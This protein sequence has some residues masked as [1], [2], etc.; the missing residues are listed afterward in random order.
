M[1]TISENL[2][3]SIKA[4][5]IH[6][7]DAAAKYPYRKALAEAQWKSL[8][9]RRTG[10]ELLRAFR[11]SLTEKS[12]IKPQEWQG[13]GAVQLISRNG[14]SAV[15]QAE[16]ATLEITFLAS[17]LVRVR[18]YQPGKEHPPVPYAIAKPEEDWT[19]L[20]PLKFTQTES[21]LLMTTDKLSLG[22]SLDDATIFFANANGDLMR[23]DVDMAWGTDGVVRHRT[24]MVAEEHI[25]GLGERATPWN[26][27]RRTHILWNTDPAGYTDND[28][29]INMNIPTYV[30]V[31]NAGSYLVFYENTYYAEFDMGE[32]LPNIAEHRFAG[33]ELRYYIA[34][35]STKT[36]IERYTELT[37][38][39][40]LQPLWMLG[41]QQSRWS[42]YPEE[43]V[44]KLAQD[45]R[46]HDVP[47]D[48]IHLDI[49]YME[50]FRNFTWD[51]ERFPDLARLAADLRE[52]GIK[53]I[54]IID[55]GVKKDPDYDTYRT[56]M[57]GDLFCKLPD[58]KTFHAP[59]WPGMCAFPDFTDSRTRRWWGANYRSLLEAGIAGFW[60]DMNEP[61][62][63][64]SQT[65]QTL[66][67]TIYHDME[68]QGGDHRE[69]HNIYGMQMVRA[70]REGL[71]KL[72]PDQRPVVM[73]RAGWAG[74][75]R[76][77]TS[78][79]A[80]N[81]STWNSLRLTIPLVTALGLSGVSFTG[82]D[83]GGFTKEA[84][85]ELFTRWL[86][87]GVFMPFFRAH[88]VINTP[89]QE[90]WA[91]GEPYLSI[92]R[93]FIQLRYELLP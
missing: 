35:G 4:I 41:Y 85:G 80:D 25:F 88:T 50:G 72:Q 89:D 81:E 31:H 55:A 75:Q 24:S 10:A 65:G 63:F 30:G 66:P 43:R 76:H 9:E 86:Q 52:Q 62:V 18:A 71:L 93:R 59:V 16:N 68:G 69:A 5:G 90:P 6:N 11:Q 36:L 87:M 8:T 20:P 32:S 40:D 28:E 23:V 79:T 29:P 84:D 67:D 39:H 2:L 92:V 22:V 48:A 70:T 44:R 12:R 53:L 78:W 58:G 60:N 83:I 74:V 77:S 49:D 7:V 33:G 27:R 47:C 73:T 15:I 64:S 14:R 17:D 42:Y 26:R 19:D 37:G 38:R 57:Q 34:I 13:T 61:A 91:Y 54:A 56:G 3:N 21:A 45:F 1:P 82:S 51:K 46:E